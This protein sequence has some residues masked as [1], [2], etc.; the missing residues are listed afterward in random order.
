LWLLRVSHHLASF[1]NRRLRRQRASSHTDRTGRQRQERH[2]TKR[3]KTDDPCHRLDQLR[4]DHVGQIY[5]TRSN[6]ASDRRYKL[7][8]KQQFRIEFHSLAFSILLLRAFL[9]RSG[10]RP[11]ARSSE[12]WIAFT[13]LGFL[14]TGPDLDPE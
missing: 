12:S 4:R 13:C 11:S 8:P 14:T 6:A 1:V 7:K 9:P 3:D 5:H 2:D 10:M